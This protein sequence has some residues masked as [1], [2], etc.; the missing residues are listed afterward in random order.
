MWSFALGGLA[1]ALAMVMLVMFGG[2]GWI[3]AV[4]TG[5]LLALAVGGFLTIVLGRPL[6]T[7][8]EV[9]ARTAPRA[10]VS[11]GYAAAV[12]PAVVAET[13]MPAPVPVA[14]AEAVKPVFLTAAR[15]GQA[16]DLKLI[17]GV[18]PKLEVMLHGMGVYHFDQI[19]GWSDAEVAWVDDNLEGFKGRVSRDGW[20]AQA[21]ILAAGGTV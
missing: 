4:F 13:P 17:K 9:Q 5:A 2:F 1:G 15:S 11:H 6:P 18:G 12:Q 14:T 20:V 10:P 3:G 19:A 21:R 8:A 16:D 7:M